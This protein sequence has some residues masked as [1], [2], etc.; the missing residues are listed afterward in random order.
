MA[1]REEGGWLGAAACG[2]AATLA[3][4][5]EGRQVGLCVRIRFLLGGGGPG[6]QSTLPSSAASVAVWLSNGGGTDASAAPAQI[7]W[8]AE[9]CAATGELWRSSHALA[10]RPRGVLTRSNTRLNRARPIE[11]P[12]CLAQFSGSKAANSLRKKA[13]K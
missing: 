12:A 9:R 2:V 6:H 3:S 7:Q 11:R 4:L 1:A 10:L 5:G 13:S 8:R